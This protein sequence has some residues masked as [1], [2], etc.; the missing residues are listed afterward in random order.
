MDKQTLEP[1]LLL[2]TD[3]N[4]VAPLR[5][6]FDSVGEAVQVEYEPSDWRLAMATR[7]PV[8]RDFL[9]LTALPTSWPQHAL[10]RLRTAA[11]SA[12]GAITSFGA[13]VALADELT[14]GLN[15]DQIDSLCYLLG[16]RR[17]LDID[18][19]TNPT[20]IYVAAGNAQRTDRLLLCEHIYVGFDPAP[21]AVSGHIEIGADVRSRWP[22]PVPVD[23]EPIYPGLSEQPVVLHVLHDWGGGIARFVA[24]LAESDPRRIHLALRARGSWATRRYGSSL[25]LSLVDGGIILGNWPLSAAIGSIS[26]THP[27]YRELMAQVNQRYGIAAIIVSSLIGHSLDAL[28][29]GLPTAVVA[30]DYFPL[31]PELHCNF[32]DVSRRFDAKERA[33]TVAAMAANGLFGEHVP[34][35]WQDIYDAYVQQLLKPELQ[36]AAPS[37]SVIDNLARI[38][39]ELKNK[40]IELIPHGLL[41][42]PEPQ[43][44]VEADTDGPLRLL[45]PGRINGGKGLDLLLGALPELAEHAELYLLGCGKAGEALFGVGGVHIELDYRHDEFPQRVARIRPHAALLLSTVAESFSY[46]LSEVWS[47]GVVP[48]ATRTGAFA[49]RI[50]DGDNGMLFAADAR[51]LIT[52]VRGLARDRSP[53]DALRAALSPES[54]RS[55]SEMAADYEAWLRVPAVPTTLAP[56]PPRSDDYRQ[57]QLTAER[58]GLHRRAATLE[59]QTHSQQSQLEERAVWGYELDRRLRES[60]DWAHQLEEELEERGRQLRERNDCAQQLEQDL[61]ERGAWGFELDRQLRERTDWAHQL[62]QELEE[63]GRQL[64]QRNDWA[65]QLEQDLKERGDWGLELDRQLRECT[66]WAH[67]LQQDLAERDTVITQLGEQLRGSEL[68]LEMSIEARQRLTADRQRLAADRQEKERIHLADIA[69]LEAERN[70]LSLLNEE[71]NL[72][73]RE[74]LSSTSWRITAPLRRLVLGARRIIPGL[75]FRLARARAL[76]GRLRGS[77]AR[78]GLGGTI[79]R[80]SE[81]MRHSPPPE[82][83]PALNKPSKHPQAEFAPFGV[84]SSDQPKVSVIIP[85]YGKLAY[86]V[87][88]LQSLAACADRSAMEIIVVDDCSPD[89]S[90]D[91]LTAVD[92]LRLIRNEENLGFIGACNAGAAAARGE[93]LCFLNNDTAVQ[94][95]WMDAL[96]DTFARHP[97]CGLA[98]SKL[99][100]P[101]GRLQEAGGII[102]SD[103]GGWNYGRFE[104]PNDPR[105]DYEREVDYCSG[106]SILVRAELFD[107]F[108]GFDTLYKPAYYED[109]DLAFKVR[110]AGLKVIY[111]PRSQVVHYEGISSGTDT[112]TGIKRF[113]PINQAKFLQRWADALTRQPEHDAEKVNLNCEHR[114]AGRILIIDAT[115]PTPDQDSGSVRMMNLLRLLVSEGWKV[116][117]FAD[118]RAY[119]EGYSEA[120][121]DLGVE[122]QFHPWLNDPVEFFRRRGGEFDAVMACRHYVASQYTELVRQYCPKARYLFDTVDLHYLREQR[123]AKIENDPALVKQAE[124]TRKQELA[125]IAAA[126]ITLVVS[127]TE[128]SLLATEAADARV[129]ILSN[130]HTV[131]GRSVEF[132]ERQGILFVGGFQHTPNVDAVLWF[133][134]EIWPQVHQALPEAKFLIVGSRMPAEVEEL[135]KQSGVVARGFVEE[136]DPLLD[137]CRIAVAPLRYGAGVKGKV[138]SSMAHGQPVVMTQIAAEG[139]HLESGKHGLIS[140]DPGEFAEAVIKLYTD[141]ELWQVISDG[142]IANVRENFSLESALAALRGILYD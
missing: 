109:T 82:T 14:E 32:G 101:D 68:T 61:D 99:V 49:E 38:S 50:S 105:F 135:G 123:A 77:L 25:E 24:D 27:G 76:F 55:A 23:F 87:T 104:Q 48:L 107:Q 39:P 4:I 73:K 131:P 112:S 140:D 116:V 84:P 60:T 137:G 75:N 115:T 80:V 51:A 134:S 88:C 74:I 67:Q 120:V 126:D 37:Q 121:R 72:A 128:K 26:L 12:P 41:P 113:Q 69:A 83:P 34:S 65:Q 2:C 5:T 127:P 117:F 94:P 9:W 44:S 17:L 114:V 33:E 28:E 10:S 19:L 52:L 98:G 46:T 125:L 89:D 138:N 132:A 142:G 110:D 31:W 81:E 71:L 35:F 136:L 141:P 47:L 56:R 118:N 29:T 18:V 15:A 139:M 43:P 102:F 30:H 129:E 6:L 130:I 96:V 97:K 16:E 63:R 79:G 53:L 70:G 90:A 86:T 133:V 124:A 21:T 95:G 122:V 36:M 1:L 85:I 78:R 66:D 62:Q 45:I 59:A 91:R 22:S 93:F 40:P 8:E 100:Y 92:G 58:D 119:V 108:G 64:R 103:G 106:A 3:R 13:G 54:M 20:L 111:Q 7:G 11:A 57:L 42:W